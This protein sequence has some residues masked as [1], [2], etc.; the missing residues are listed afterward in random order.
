M[1]EDEN[2][3]INK[4]EAEKNFHSIN[5]IVE[6]LREPTGEFKSNDDENTRLKS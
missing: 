5:K 4:E 2:Y 3:S 1:F 6:E